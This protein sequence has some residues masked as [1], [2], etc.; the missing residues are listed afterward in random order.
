MFLS[1]VVCSSRLLEVNQ[2]STI[3]RQIEVE[4]LVAGTAARKSTQSLR[5]TQAETASRFLSLRAA[6]SVTPPMDSTQRR[7]SRASSTQSREGVLIVLPSKIPLMSLPFFVNRKSFG[8]GL[9]GW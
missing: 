1:I 9:S 3:F 4:D 2:G 8:R 5:S 7:P 6:S